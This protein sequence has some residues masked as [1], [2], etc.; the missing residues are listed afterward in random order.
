MFLLINIIGLIVFLGIAVL[1]SRKKSD[2]Q[3]KS[4]GI[5]VVINLFLAWFFMYFPWGKLAV[6]LLANGISWV[7]DSA[8]VGTGFAFASWTNTEMMDMAVSALFPILLVV[9]L[10]DI[11]M[12]FNILPKVIG[13]IGWALAKI[14]RQPKFE[15]FFGIEMMFLGNTEA[16]AVS[17]EQ[18]KR[19]KETRVLTVAMMSMSSISGAIVG[20]YVSMIPGDLV[21]TAIP[22]NII[23]AI[24]VSSIL[25]PVS[26]EEKEDIIYSIRNEEIEKQPFFSF[27]GDSVLNAGKLILIIIAF[28]ISFVALSDLID[29]FINLITGIIAGW[30]GIKGS[31]GLDQILGTFMYPFALLL[32]LP[33]DEAWIVA[34]Q[35]AKK[36]VTNEF[37]VMGQIKDVIDSYSPHRRAVI[38]TFL[39]SFANFS[40]IGMIIGTLK[41]IVDKKTSDFV[42]QYVPMMLLA[43]ILV[44]LMTAGFVGLF[45]W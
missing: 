1:F 42:S 8:H 34:Q 24:I 39:V 18:L 15:S 5:L 25:N 37:V 43:G 3:W 17:N 33:F 36:I 32:G 19:M 40:T 13:G 11:L 22:L 35:M 31:F 7:I 16:L 10:F 28:V 20:A 2:I 21:L 26:V 12:Y 45:A 4:I 9:P 38:A 6:Q 29:R 23:N 27:L 44:S 41:G 30:A 14:T